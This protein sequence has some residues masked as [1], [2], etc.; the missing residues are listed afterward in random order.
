MRQNLFN[1]H[2]IKFYLFQYEILFKNTF[3]RKQ[4]ESKGTM[5]KGTR[6]G[7]LVG[8]A[9]APLSPPVPTLVPCS[10]TFFLRTFVHNPVIIGYSF[11]RISQSL[12]SIHIM[13]FEN[14]YKYVPRPSSIVSHNQPPLSPAKLSILDLLA[15]ADKAVDNSKPSSS[16]SQSLSLWCR[17]SLS[18]WC[19]RSLSPLCRRSTS[20]QYPS[21]MIKPTT[22][23]NHLILLLQ[24]DFCKELLKGSRSLSPRVLHFFNPRRMNGS[25]RSKL[26]R[27]GS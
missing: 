26:T 22:C 18:P 24:G 16:P 7:T 20:P 13:S 4:E 8:P 27:M 15:M 9:G 2:H 11:V 10:S 5:Q 17:R 25:C 1:Y 3:N 14:P 19:H 21:A 6:S 12:E 23:K